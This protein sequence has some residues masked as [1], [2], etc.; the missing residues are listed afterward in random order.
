MRQ[1]HQGQHLDRPGHQDEQM[2]Q[3][4]G[5]QADQHQDRRDEQI[6]PGHLGRRDDQHLGR[7]DDRRPGHLGDQR[8]DRYE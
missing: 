4:Q 3:R 1:G 8:R 6:R 7:R 2:H 5:H